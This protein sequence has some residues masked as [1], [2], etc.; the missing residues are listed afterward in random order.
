[1]ME[2]E[3]FIDILGNNASSISPLG[4]DVEEGGSSIVLVENKETHNKN[5]ETPSRIEQTF[6]FIDQ[7][8][9]GP[10]VYFNVFSILMLIIV[11]STCSGTYPK[12]REE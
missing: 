10:M 8:L 7:Y 2:E 11:A 9:F 6:N 12:N 5:E 3:E 4:N 1:M